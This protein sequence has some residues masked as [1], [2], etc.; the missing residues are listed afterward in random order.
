MD[1]RSAER[2]SVLGVSVLVG[3]GGGGR[4]RSCGGW[5]VL[6]A[7][8]A[9]VGRP[10]GVGAGV[11]AFCPGGS[12]RRHCRR[13]IGRK[14]F[15][16]WRGVGGGWVAAWLGGGFWGG[17]GGRPPLPPP[18]PCRSPHPLPCSPT[19]PHP[20]PLHTPPPASEPTLRAGSRATSP[21]HRLRHA[22]SPSR[23]DRAKEQGPGVD[24]GPRCGLG[25][26]GVFL[27]SPQLLAK[28]PGWAW[29]ASR[30]PRRQSRAEIKTTVNQF[31][32]RFSFIFRLC[33]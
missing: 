30:S 32:R 10:R 19:F 23:G 12:P 29:Y 9:F 21:R 24:S 20:P 26:L 8:T 4:W 7:G 33:F 6:G 14:S 25:A 16:S 27:G 18:P 31:F 22:R 11:W 1:D 28:P 2:S 13:T 15:A 17:G 3:G 5:R